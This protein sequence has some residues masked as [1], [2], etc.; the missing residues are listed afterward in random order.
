MVGSCFAL[1]V[2]TDVGLYGGAGVDLILGCNGLVW[3]GP[4]D[5]SKNG[6]EQEAAHAKEEAVLVMPTM[7][8]FTPQQRAQASRAANAVCALAALY[9]PIHSKSI[10]DTCQARPLL[11]FQLQLHSSVLCM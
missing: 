8:S 11:A 5:A 1:H 2:L 10:L 3:V 7:P 4:H 6:G 9:L